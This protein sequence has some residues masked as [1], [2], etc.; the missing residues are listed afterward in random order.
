MHLRKAVI[1]TDSAGISDYVTAGHNGILCKASSP[2]ELAG[3]MMKLWTDRDLT[4]RLAAANE[5]FGA[6]YC[7]EHVARRDLAE[8]MIRHGLLTNPGREDSAP[9]FNRL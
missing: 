9:S 3:A 6:A 7:T 1:A 4:A 5:Q 2:T 8:L